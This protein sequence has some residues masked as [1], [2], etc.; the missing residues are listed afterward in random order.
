M[1]KLCQKR[2]FLAG[3]AKI[4]FPSTL[5][6]VRSVQFPRSDYATEHF[7]FK[8]SPILL[9]GGTFLGFDQERN[10]K[11]FAFF[12]AA[13]LT[14]VLKG[15]GNRGLNLLSARETWNLNRKA[16]VFPLCFVSRLPE[17]QAF[18]RDT[19]PRKYADVFRFHCPE[20]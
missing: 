8:F 18:V 13:E 10:S 14:S 16:S 9:D 6:E 3:T 2:P 7:N 11:A 19:Q 5:L 17:V 15:K 1:E 4:L 20:L 12:E